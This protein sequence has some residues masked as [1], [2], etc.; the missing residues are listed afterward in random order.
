MSLLHKIFTET[1]SNVKTAPNQEPAL[2]ST[3]KSRLLEP[4]RWRQT[5]HLVTSWQQQRQEQ[6]KH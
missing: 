4:V 1:R 3:S 2:S 5:H 6:Q